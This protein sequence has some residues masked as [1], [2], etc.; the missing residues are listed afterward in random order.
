MINKFSKIVVY[1]LPPTFK[2]ELF[3]E[4]IKSY[5]TFADFHYFVKGKI[6]LRKKTP[7]R[8]YLNFKNLDYVE[9]F[10]NEFNSKVFDDEESGEWKSIFF[11]CL[12]FH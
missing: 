10:Y 3:W 8:A 12:F 5:L 11:F 1:N 7:S 6:G 2:E 4:T 9:K